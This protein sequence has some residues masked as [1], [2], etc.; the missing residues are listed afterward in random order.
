[1]KGR[2]TVNACK[3]LRLQSRSF[4]SSSVLCRIPQG[5]RSSDSLPQAR[6]SWS[7]KSSDLAIAEINVKLRK[8]GVNPADF[9]RLEAL[10]PLARTLTDRKGEL[11]RQQSAIIAEMKRRHGRKKS[12]AVNND[13]GTEKIDDQESDEQLKARGKS[14]KEEILPIDKELSALGLESQRIRLR[15]PNLT[16]PNSPLGGIENAIM[17]GKGGDSRLLQGKVRDAFVKAVLPIA[18][19]EVPDLDHG[20][21]PD[22]ERDHVS[23]ARQQGWMDSRTEGFVAGTSWPVMRG[24]LAALEH[25]LVGYA[26]DSACKANFEPVV[27]PDVVKRDVIER[28]GFAPR[29]GGGGQ[30]Y[31]LSADGS[32]KNSDKGGDLA[33]A[34]TAEIPLAG[35]CAGM[36]YEADF[37]PEQFVAT[38]HAFRAEAGARGLDSKGLYRVH[39]F[40]KIEMFVVCRADQSEAWL[41]QILTVQEDI[42]SA[43]GI[44]YRVINMPTEELGA[45]AFTKYDIEAWM[46]GRGSWGEISSASNCTDYQARRLHI[47][48]KADG[49]TLPIG[50]GLSKQAWAHT[51]NGTAIAVPRIIVALLEN[52][53]VSKDGKIRLPSVL[54]QYW[55]PIAQDQVEWVDV[56][57]VKS[58]AKGTT[59]RKSAIERVKRMAEERGTDAASMVVSFLILHEL[60]AIIPLI[61][62]FYLL[63]FFGVGEQV[64]NWLLQ[65]S[66]D[67]S[68][69][70]QWLRGKINEGMQR[71]ESYG[72]K[73]GFFGFEAHSSGEIRATATTSMLVGTFANV[74]AAYAITKALFPLRIGACIALAA[75]FARV[76]IEPVKRVILK[77]RTRK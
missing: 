32:S 4:G 19:N 10:G 45:S 55:M 69:A 1:M 6:P 30:I 68:S 66:E 37:T 57:P 75:P 63:G 11:D 38:S 34:A 33:L 8:G 65:V 40:T 58:S 20:N 50:E 73:K 67:D 13:I 61:L 43:L 51:L 59:N 62:I 64:M 22:T 74:V 44:P 2:C 77:T 36:T 28:T 16:N 26:M 60:T 7:A 31:W 47:R 54:K 56:L 5:T 15:L 24:A 48:Y 42:I 49:K 71:A 25:A 53:G 18:L 72:R 46:P 76:F 3:D 23:L 21:G 14:I 9:K 41:K 29:Q 39:Q 52:Y 35:M 17:I 12:K 70:R 27:V